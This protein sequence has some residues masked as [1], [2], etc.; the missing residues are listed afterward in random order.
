[1]EENGFFWGCG[2]SFV[3]LEG[4][5]KVDCFEIKNKSANNEFM[6]KEGNEYLEKED[7]KPHMML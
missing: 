7:V 1:M 2:N 4:G 3:T 6:W 5:G